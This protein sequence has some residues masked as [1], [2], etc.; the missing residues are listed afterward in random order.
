MSWARA[1]CTAA[2]IVVAI[3][4]CTS[5]PTLP[6]RMTVVDPMQLPQDYI[7]VGGEWRDVRVLPAGEHAIDL[8]EVPADGV[9]HLSFF[10][11]GYSEVAPSASVFVGKTH[12]Q[13]VSFDGTEHWTDARIDLSPYAGRGV[14]CRVLFA[15]E[16]DIKLSS[17][18]LTAADSTKPNVLIFLVDTLR[19]DRLGCYGYERN[20]SPSIDALALEGFQIEK[21]ISQS[22]WTRPAVASLLTSTYPSTHRTNDRANVLRSSL[23]TVAETLRRSGYFTHA[24]MSNP[25]CLPT[26]GFGKGFARFR[27]VGS[28]T[29]NPKKD[30]DVVDAVL[31]ALDYAE[32]M[33]WF[34]YV[35]TMGPHSPYEPPAPYDA[36]FLS[37]TSG[38]SEQDA[39]R[40][41]L[42]DLYDGEIAF[43]DAQLGRLVGALKERGIYDNTVI[44]VLSDHGEEFWEHGGWGHGHSLFDEVV[45]IPCVVKPTARAA[46]VKVSTDGVC[47]IVDVAPTMLEL[48]GLPVPEEFEGRSLVAGAHESPSP[49]YAYSSLYLEKAS[50][51]S[52]RSDS[53]KYI[54]NIKT[55]MET[56]Y[57]LAADPMELAPLPEPPNQ[58]IDLAQHASRIAR[59]ERTGLNILITGSLREPYTIEGLVTG[60]GLG[61]YRLQ[62]LAR[63]GTIASTGDGVSFR[64]TTSP[65]PD[66][67]PQ[68]VE[69]H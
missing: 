25:T 4:G 44:A 46:G 24:F 69:W 60:E 34:F 67:H 17:C 33:P 6:D 11:R 41:K 59:G 51:Y 65:G 22:S 31:K 35:H 66:S 29:L 16:T 28:F 32:G 55:D 40:R 26:W 56:W 50:A 54:R 53:L 42:Q 12:I 15:S 62:Y 39:E 43:T 27:D 13:A 19:R 64:V 45:R 23:T 37:D 5:R 14:R 36:Q 38:L 10:P 9:L 49:Q 8:G 30:A 20:T 1:W 57:D 61:A 58:N 18:G 3:C 7:E 48:A 68:I 63:N 2:S 21:M 52:A 47:E